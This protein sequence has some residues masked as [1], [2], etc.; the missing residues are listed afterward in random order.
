MSDPCDLSAVELRR[1]IGAKQLSPRELLAS[2]RRRIERVNGT[3]NAVVAF[4]EAGA[5]EAVV[6]PPVRGGLRG[7]W[8]VFRREAGNSPPGRRL[9]EYHFEPEKAEMQEADQTDQDGCDGFHARSLGQ[10]AGALPA[11]NTAPSCRPS[12]TTT[13]P[14]NGS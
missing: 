4:D 2:C 1:L 3:V 8:G 9:P 10:A 12:R 5:E 14:G 6:R 13:A 11:E 7:G